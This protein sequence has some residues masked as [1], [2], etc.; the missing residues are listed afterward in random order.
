[1][2]LATGAFLSFSKFKTS[3]SPAA[4]Y[5][6]SHHVVMPESHMIIKA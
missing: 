6:Q 5:K 3:N 1:L 4:N 2:H